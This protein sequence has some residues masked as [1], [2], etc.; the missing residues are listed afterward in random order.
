MVNPSNHKTDKGLHYNFFPTKTEL[1]R[2]SSPPGSPSQVHHLHCRLRF[3]R[4][5]G[6]KA[7][8]GVGVKVLLLIEEV[9]TCEK[10]QPGKKTLESLHVILG[11][12]N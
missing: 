4:P 10:I 9:S 5:Q 8:A 11:N 6:L 2:G 7:L 1:H 12:L 3:A